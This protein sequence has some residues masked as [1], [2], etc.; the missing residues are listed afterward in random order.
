MSFSGQQ[1]NE[2]TGVIRNHPFYPDISLQE[3]VE[4]YS[5]PTTKPETLVTHLKS[6]IIEINYRLD[7]YRIEQV[8]AGYLHLSEVPAMI[9][10]EQSAL[11]HLY[12][13]A[14]CFQAKASILRDYATIDRRE[15]AENQAKTSA[16]LEALYELWATE[17]V[18]K[19]LKQSGTQV[20]LS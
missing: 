14:V 11:I 20:P 16:D 6:A 13:Q 10:D 5:I 2:V 17:A 19:I 9:I 7:D 8:N 12:I 1:Y 18:N 3:F 4:N 15:A